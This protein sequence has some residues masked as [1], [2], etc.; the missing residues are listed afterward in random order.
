[1]KAL[2]IYESVHHGNTKKIAE[3]ISEALKARLERVGDARALE[4]QEYG[5]VGFGSG[6][7]FGR[8]HRRLLDFVGSLPDERGK[9]AFLFSTAGTEGAEKYHAA[10]RETVVAKGFRI[11][12]E[13]S[14][15]GHD[16]FG[17]FRL[18]GGLNKGRPDDRDVAAAVKF[19]KGIGRKMG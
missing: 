19:A 4:L 17:P 1:M 13:F 10:L 18:V 16:T 9:A 3:A 5:L 14:C 11:V 15:P 7:F 12:G 2:V 6:I 8:H